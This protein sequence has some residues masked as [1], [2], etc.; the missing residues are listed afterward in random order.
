MKSID[1]F[2]RC[3]LMASV[4]LVSPYKRILHKDEGLRGKTHNV[5]LLEVVNEYKS[6]VYVI[7]ALQ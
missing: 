1:A 7:R 2:R 3:E 6:F 5:A 4:R